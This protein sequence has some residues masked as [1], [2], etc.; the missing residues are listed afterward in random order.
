MVVKV[1]IKDNRFILIESRVEN[2]I[3]ISKIF[4]YQDMSNCF[5]GGKFKKE[6]IKDVCFLITSPKTPTSALLPIGF[7][8]ELEKYL[9]H[10]NAKYV[11]HDER[12]SDTWKYTYDEIQKSL[13]YIELYDYQVESVQKCLDLK[14]GIIKASTGAGKTEIFISLCKLTNKKT[15]I[16]FARIALAQQT[17][18]RMKKAGLD[19]GIVQG[20]KIDDKHQIVMATVQSGHKLNKL[21]DYEMIIIDECF[22][23]GTF[24][25]TDSGIMNIRNIVENKLTPNVL[26]YNEEKAIF[27]YRKVYDWY[28]K[29]TEELYNISVDNKISKIKATPN[30]PF[31][32]ED[33]STKRADELKIGDKIISIISN[34]IC[35]RRCRSLTPDRKSALL[36]IALGNGYIYKTK[37]KAR[38]RLTYEEKHL[39][40]LNDIITLFNIFTDKVPREYNSSKNSYQIIS[41]SSI[42]IKEIYDKLYQNRKKTIYNVFDDLNEISLAY[43]IMDNGYIDIYYLRDGTEKWLYRIATYC[44]TEAEHDFMIQKFKEKFDLDCTKE[45]DKTKNVWSIHFNRESSEKLANMIA[46]YILRSMEYKLPFIMRNTPKYVYEKERNFSVSII[47]SIEVLKIHKDV[48]NISVENNHNYIINSGYLVKNCHRASGD[49]YRELMRRSKARYRFGFS[50]TPFVKDQYKAALVR[51]WIG[52]LIYEVDSRKLLQ[53]KRIATPT[54]RMIPI[55]E[56]KNISHCRWPVVENVGIVE[57]SYR[58]RIIVN[59]TKMLKGQTLILVKLLDH[60]DYLNENIPNSVWLSGKNKDKER[61]DII[62]RFDAGEDFVLIAST[63]FDEGID[64]KTVKH[65]ILCGGGASYVKILQRI[66]RGMRVTETKTT[67]DVYDFYD[68]TNDILERHAKERIKTYKKEGYDDIRMVD[69]TLIKKLGKLQ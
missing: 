25:H 13:G 59:L 5:V 14:S 52:S 54:I 19:A 41:Q 33:F 4:T 32:L 9:I 6:N 35:N 8:Y 55:S 37:N 30:H 64:I 7:L 10:E 18:N 51:M 46:P 48:Y 29:T 43:W 27:E 50:A 28:K 23:S 44:F 11:I 62:K 17:L 57:N 40:Y 22:P 31:Y 61:N 67:V 66:G 58:N 21:E 38:I 60:G 63:I 68:T 69:E 16:L 65:V 20:S 34:K 3:K 36:G 42:E 15:L 24:V 39:E 45:F 2:L 26:S 12:K 47:K 49:Q 56:P 53:E 1:T